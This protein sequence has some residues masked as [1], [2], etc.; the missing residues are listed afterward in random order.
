MSTTGGALLLCSATSSAQSIDKLR[1]LNTIQKS[2]LETLML[3]SNVHQVIN[4]LCQKNVPYHHLFQYFTA[5]ANLKIFQARVMI[6][7]GTT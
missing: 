5:Y 4:G 3:A 6:D 1:G 2:Q 7:L